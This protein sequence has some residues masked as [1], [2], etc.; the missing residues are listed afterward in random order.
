MVLFFSLP[1]NRLEGARVRYAKNRVAVP[2]A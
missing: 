1:K 2:M